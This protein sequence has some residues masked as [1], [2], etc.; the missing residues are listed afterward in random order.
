MVDPKWMQYVFNDDNDHH[1]TFN[2]VPF[3]VV[4]DQDPGL[5][6]MGFGWNYLERCMS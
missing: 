1:S 6:A 3:V 5:V 2:N 4:I